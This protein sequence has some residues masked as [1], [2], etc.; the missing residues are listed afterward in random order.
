M[1]PRNLPFIKAHGTGNDFVLIPDLMAEFALSAE[2]VRALCD[3]H[4]GIGADGVI[5]IIRSNADSATFFMDYRNA[6]GSLAE[7]CG[8]GARIFVAYLIREGL[9]EG[10]EVEFDTRAGRLQAHVYSASDIEIDMGEPSQGPEFERVTIHHAGKSFPGAA[11]HV[12]NPHAVV[13]VAELEAI[14]ALTAA[15]AWQP[16]EAF[17]EGANVEFVEYLAP[18]H[19]RMRVWE[20]GVGETLSCGTGAC[21]VGLVSRGR[22]PQDGATWRVDVPGGTVFVR[23]GDNGH[24]FLRGPVTFVAEGV[25]GLANG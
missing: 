9:V 13:E 19:V 16:G 3:R 22:H 2:D 17:P 25:T 18:G 1:N 21:A 7:M 11:V 12:P 10:P 8:N 14:G 24:V 4:F 20:R 5:R 15:P 6:D 23:V